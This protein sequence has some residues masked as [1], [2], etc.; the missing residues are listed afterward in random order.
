MLKHNSD[1]IRLRRGGQ[2]RW[3]DASYAE[4]RMIRKHTVD[5]T[6]ECR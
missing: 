2:H 1:D 3:Q 4:R 6:A 5:K